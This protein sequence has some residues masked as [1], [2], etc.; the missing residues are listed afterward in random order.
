M[1]VGGVHDMVVFG[2]YFKP[3]LIVV[4]DRHVSFVQVGIHSLN[5]QKR[6]RNQRLEAEQA[7]ENLKDTVHKSWFVL[8]N[9]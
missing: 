4:S 7:L 2:F 5:T 1:A 9:Y 6:M 3:E 8:Q